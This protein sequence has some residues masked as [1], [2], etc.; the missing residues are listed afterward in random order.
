LLSNK[1]VN[2]DFGP[3]EMATITQ[4]IPEACSFFEPEIAL[5]LIYDI[6]KQNNENSEKLLSE[7]TEM[8][9]QIKT[10]RESCEAQVKLWNNELQACKNET[11]QCKAE[12]QNQ[13][14]KFEAEIETFKAE[15]AAW[16]EQ[17]TNATS[18]SNS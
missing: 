10:D 12:A 18:K 16:K 13:I 4:N 5:E 6:S 17:N 8:K 7:Q 1:C 15:S 2:K 9:T 11:I 3:S 14:K